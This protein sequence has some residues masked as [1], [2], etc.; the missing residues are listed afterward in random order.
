MSVWIVGRSDY[1]LFVPLPAAIG[2]GI[3]GIFSLIAYIFA[4]GS[5]SYTVG[6]LAYLLTSST[7]G[8]LILLTGSL[9]SPFIALWLLIGVFA[10]IFGWGVWLALLSIA[11]IHLLYEL[12]LSGKV[13]GADQI[14]EMTL[15]TEAPILVSYL[16]WHKKSKQEDAKEQKAV[17]ALEQQL[18]Q[19]ASKS[20][21]VVNSIAEGVLVVDGNGVIQLVNP[22]AETLLGWP[23]QDAVNLDYRSIFKLS[24]QNAKPV[25]DDFSPVRQVLLSNKPLVT[26]DLSLTT[27]SG[28]RIDIS[29]VVS[30]V[31]NTVPAKGAIAVFRDITA[32]KQE[33]RQKAEFISTASHEMRTPVA[34]IEGY[35]ALA[36]N[37]QTATID[38]KAQA[39]LHKAHESTQ[40]LGRLFQDLLTV[41]KAEDSRL[42][43]HPGPV[44]V[45]GFMRNL[46][47]SLQPKAREKNI[48]LHFKP[49]GEQRDG[50][51]QIMPVYYANVDQDHLREVMNNLIDNA[52]KYTK[53]GTVT[54][55]V[56]GDSTTITLSVTD[57]GF[58]IPPEDVPHLFQKFY[59]VDNT[60]TREIGGTG[61]GL[62]ICRRL[63]EANNG[64]IAVKSTYGKGST[65][66]VQL[67]RITN[68]QA[69]TLQNTSNP[70]Q[71]QAL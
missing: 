26:N 10:G 42:I 7:A 57:T 6:L 70:T 69:T 33:E 18:S 64:R 59:R 53:Q 28:K 61:L 2:A 27:K 16:I 54:V 46:T 55:D 60:D 25:E 58:G 48:F 31:G 30:P 22:A 5:A 52:I 50:P 35:L 15:I 65:F 63:V 32:E 1:A 41:S 4:R 66:M 24:D 23:R 47:E 13:F 29:L 17:T 39:Y 38:E 21:I 45:V 36:M 3:T 14:I 67:P 44:D 8:L 12:F 11:N 62:Y 37:P 9:R 43:A 51:R 49:G 34:A 71:P 68:E 56:T 20:D 19:V 40:H